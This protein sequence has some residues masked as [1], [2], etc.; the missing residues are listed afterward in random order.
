MTRPSPASPTPDPSSLLGKCEVAT[1]E[2]R[3][4][5]KPIPS[6]FLCYSKRRNGWCWSWQPYITFLCLS[7][8]KSD[9]ASLT[10]SPLSEEEGGGHSDHSL[11]N[12]SIQALPLCC[13]ALLL[14]SKERLGPWP[15]KRVGHGHKPIRPVAKESV[16]WP[17]RRE[18]G[19][20]HTL[21]PSSLLG[22]CEVASPER[23]RMAKPIPHPFL[24][25]AVRRNWW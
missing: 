21:R 14:L 2:R 13:I 19:H 3:R 1:P 11:R 10:P 9:H 15:E 12:L 18:D 22:K 25:Y 17:F 6:P 24:R 23:R 8:G 20:G 16:R 4:M 7:S 5:V